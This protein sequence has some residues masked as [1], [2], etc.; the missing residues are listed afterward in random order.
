[1]RPRTF[2]PCLI[3]ITSLINFHLF[4]QDS[5]A[6]KDTLKTAAKDAKKKEW[7]VTASLGPSIDVEFTTTEGTWM[8]LDVSPD[9]KEILFD[10]LGDIYI[11]R[12][13]HVQAEQ[14]YRDALR[15]SQEV[16]AADSFGKLLDAGD[17]SPS[18]L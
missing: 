10:L 13:L 7:D 16:V 6:E 8:N 14:R 5:A 9:G 11:M 17:Q 12:G 18:R 1:M 4:A 3:L 15:Y 2:I